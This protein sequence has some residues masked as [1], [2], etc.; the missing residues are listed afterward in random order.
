MSGG[1]SL[2]SALTLA[3]LAVLWIW[4]MRGPTADEDAD[5]RRWKR[6]AGAAA[7]NPEA[8]AS[9]SDLDICNAIL[10]ATKR[11]P[12]QARRRGEGR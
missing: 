4:C 5:R 9:A 8:T 6:T 12:R 3:A 10:A 1:E 7:R 11:I 2:A